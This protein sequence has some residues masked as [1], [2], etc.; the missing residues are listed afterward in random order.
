MPKIELSTGKTLEMRRPKVKDMNMIK[1]I[2]DDLERE[3]ALIMNLAELSK[4]ELEDMDIYDY[5]LLQKELVGFTST[6]PKI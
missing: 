2:K 1:D 6:K 3:Q 5:T 4:D